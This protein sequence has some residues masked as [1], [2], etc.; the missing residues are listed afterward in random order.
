[1]TSAPTAPLRAVI[2]VAEHTNMEVAQAACLAHCEE[3]GYLVKSLILGDR[4]GVRW[5][6][7]VQAMLFKGEVDVVVIYSR[8]DL[9]PA[10]LP[11]VEVVADRVTPP[12]VPR[13][14]LWRR[15]RPGPVDR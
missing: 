2:Y 15:T 8:A 11:R 13:R 14:G 12:P 9:P 10:R 4:A 5:H 6:E 7:G 1:M 3:R